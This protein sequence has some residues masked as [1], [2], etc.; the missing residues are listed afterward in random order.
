MISKREL[1]IR[2]CDLEAEVEY[3][4][5]EILEPEYKKKTTKKAKKNVK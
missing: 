4:M 5:E 2:L 3:I 1:A